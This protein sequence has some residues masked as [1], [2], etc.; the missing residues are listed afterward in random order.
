MAVFTTDGLII[1]EQKTGESDRLVT[2]LTA[3]KGLIRA[4]APRALNIKSK[5]VGATQ[6]LAY[7][8]MT[9]FQGRD[10]Y[11]I[12]E[13]ASIE[14]FMPLR[15]DMDALFLAGYLSELARTLAPQEE[16]ARDF[17]QLMLRALYLLSNKTLSPAQIK[18]V[19]EL[20]MC[21]LSGYMP[22]LDNCGRCGAIDGQMYFDA[23]G[24]TVVCENC[25]R[26]GDLPLSGGVLAAMRHIESAQDGK[27]FSFKLPRE[28][29]EMLGRI[30]ERFTLAQTDRNY[31]SLELYN[32]MQGEQK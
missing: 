6:L 17:L 23:V 3:D 28:G 22:N 1:R 30:T 12:N 31:K 29:I 5:N 27:E 4:F 11:K 16:P 13:A 26:G 18:A 14:V 25:R 32:S 7:S 20:R 2:I 19:V 10:T 15:S 9:V 21:T 8:R 24:G